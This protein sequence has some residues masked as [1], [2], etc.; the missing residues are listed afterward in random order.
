MILS[1]EPEK[2]HIL[3][4]SLGV[5]K[6]GQ[7]TKYRNHF[8]TGPGSADY[9]ICRALEADG[10]MRSRHGLSLSGGDYIFHVTKDG[11]DAVDAFSIQPP[12]LTRSQKRY[13]AWL[14]ADCNMSFGEWLKAKPLR[15]V[16][17]AL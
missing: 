1:L 6:Y 8:C 9:E 3:Q 11:E 12:L 15:D 5:D 14:D 13:R 7:G 17:V 2:I 10:L 16:P 4:H